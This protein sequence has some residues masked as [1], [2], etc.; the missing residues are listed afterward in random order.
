VI[1]Q[2]YLRIAKTDE[3]RANA[4]QGGKVM[5]LSNALIPQDVITMVDN[6]N[7]QLPSTTA[8]YTLDFIKSDNGNLYFIEGNMSPGLNWFDEE[9]ERRAKVLIRS[10]VENLKLLL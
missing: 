7:A 9:D 5:Y 2:S 6:I 10:I 1:I 3:F 4:Q 8:I